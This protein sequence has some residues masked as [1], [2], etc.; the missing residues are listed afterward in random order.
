MG[1]LRF[2]LKS[3]GPHPPRIPSYPTVP[4]IFSEDAVEFKGFVSATAQTST[5]VSDTTFPDAASGSPTSSP[6]QTTAPFGV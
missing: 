1:P 2:E 6:R 4:R 3:D 5:D